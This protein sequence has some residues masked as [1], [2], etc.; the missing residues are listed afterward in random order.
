MRKTL[1]MLMGGLLSAAMV[2]TMGGV[3]S[4]VAE[5]APN[6]VITKVEAVAK[7]K[8]PGY[9]GYFYFQTGGY[10]I[11]RDN[12]YDYA[13]YT[14]HNPATKDDSDHFGLNQRN[15][16]YGK[17]KEDG[18]NDGYYVT[19]YS[20][21]LHA[22]FIGDITVEEGGKTIT[23]KSGGVARLNYTDA[24]IDKE[25]TYSV[26][27]DIPA[28]QADLF[29]YETKSTNFA[30]S[31]G[32][33]PDTGN[34]FTMIGLSTDIPRSLNATFSNLELY[35][36][37]TKVAT[38]SGDCTVDNGG[39]KGDPAA[40]DAARIKTSGD[41]YTPMIVNSYDK[42]G[43]ASLVKGKTAFTAVPTK[44]MEL[45]F[46]V[47]GDF[48][49]ANSTTASKSEEI[50]DG[51]NNY[52]DNSATAFAKQL[53][54]NFTYQLNNGFTL[55]ADGSSEAILYDY[56][57]GKVSKQTTS[58][59]GETTTTEVTGAAIKKGESKVQTITFPEVGTTYDV[60]GST[61]TVTKACTMSEAGEVVEGE[62]EFTQAANAKAVTVEGTYKDANS[63]PYNVTSIKAKAFAKAKKCQKIT[64]SDG[65]TTINN[66]AFAGAKN[67]LKMID[68]SEN[69]TLK[70]IVGKKTF[71]F[72]NKV[73]IKV[74]KKKYSAYAKLIKK[75]GGKN[76]KKIVIK[77]VA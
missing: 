28:D 62:L 15:L 16:V 22:G 24:Y 73:T 3:N 66:L 33:H 19:D 18:S 17:V 31:N 65:I 1:K 67:K 49:D 75:A 5:A 69:V 55:N 68:M 41:Y 51:K 52:A 6:T 70:K 46:T 72:K 32:V 29:T 76:K 50:L 37:G 47:K 44:S 7:E 71:V 20:P 8:S 9:H 4:Q 35:V 34:I 13:K 11:F 59:T 53:D 58:A 63:C 43:D 54:P 39:L 2:L 10:F 26:R 45:R 56:L 64:I 21:L 61:Y 42:H 12:W 36:D 60:D 48:V 38:L 77:K 57:S 23:K 74:P 27:F 30:N 40:G 25:G 14:E